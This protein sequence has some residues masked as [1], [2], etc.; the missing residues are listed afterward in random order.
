MFFSSNRFKKLSDQELIRTYQIS[1]DERYLSEL[2]HRYAYLVLFICNKYLKNRE[3]SDDAIMEVLGKM[4]LKIS[5]LEVNN[6]KSWLYTVTKNFCL[7]KIEE[8]KD[9]GV[10]FVDISEADEIF[11]MQFPDFDCL[12]V[13]DEE[14]VDWLQKA[15][16]GLNADQKECINLFYFRKMSYHEIM[17]M[18]KWEMDQVRS[19]LQNARR[20]IRIY[21]EKRGINAK[22]FEI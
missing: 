14:K 21:L 12:I 4:S 17:E 13:G 19:H 16:D 15:I 7:N 11:F 10:E 3:E 20:N 5:E 8:N 6:F 18:K 2:L 1:L 9:L 22:T